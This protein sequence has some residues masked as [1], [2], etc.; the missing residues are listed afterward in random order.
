VA[1]SGQVTAACDGATDP[2]AA[3]GWDAGWLTGAWLAGLGLG[4]APVEL[5]APATNNDAATSA[6]RRF[7]LRMVTRNLLHAALGARL[8]TIDR[9]EQWGE[10][11]NGWFLSR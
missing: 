7:E 5:H 8:F 9:P 3:A 10:G 4:V 11:L 6:P 1:G 2:D